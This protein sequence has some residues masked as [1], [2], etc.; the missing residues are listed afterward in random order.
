MYSKEYILKKREEVKL[1]QHYLYNGKVLY[2]VGCIHDYEDD[3]AQWSISLMR[4]PDRK[5]AVRDFTVFINLLDNGHMR[6]TEVQP[7]LS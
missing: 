6:F 5:V 7:V 4:L 1:L 2:V 3:P